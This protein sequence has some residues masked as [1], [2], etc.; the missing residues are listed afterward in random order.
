MK[1][2]LDENIDVRLKAALAILGHDVTA[3]VTDYSQ[4]ITDQQVLAIAVAEER[5]LV[6]N[7]RDF[8]ELIVRSQAEHRG[9]LYLRLSTVDFAS[10]LE[11]VTVVLTTQQ[12]LLHEF[13]IVTDQRI[14][15]RQATEV[16]G[17]ED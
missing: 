12:G 7:D 8:G 16:D 5:L 11:R 6:T 2:L 4:S 3:I 13:L 14:R 9:V 17:D 10:L 15:R 1:I